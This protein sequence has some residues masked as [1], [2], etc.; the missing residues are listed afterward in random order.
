MSTILAIS[1]IICISL[2][3]HERAN[4]GISNAHG[5]WIVRYIEAQVDF[6]RITNVATLT[7]R[8]HV[9]DGNALC[10]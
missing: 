4:I 7:R 6:P 10:A 3:I 5:E 8:A 1:I 2:D 9:M